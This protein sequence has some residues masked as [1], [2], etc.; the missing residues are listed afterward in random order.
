MRQLT[1]GP[2]HASP[3]DC[4]TDR[5]RGRRLLTGQSGAPP[6]SL[7]NFSHEPPQIPE[8]WQF[9]AESASAT[10]HCPVHHQTVQCARLVLVLAI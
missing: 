5:W 8:S 6:N 9:T 3:A 10:G 4:A 7:M 2:G 1:V